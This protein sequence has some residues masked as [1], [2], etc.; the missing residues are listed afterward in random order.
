MRRKKLFA[1]VLTGMLAV[2]TTAC[3][4]ALPGSGT[5]ADREVQSADESASDPA[6]AEDAAVVDGLVGTGPYTV[7]DNYKVD[8]S[9][10]TEGPKDGDVVVDVDFDDGELDGFFTF[11]Q[12]GVEEI[13]NEDGKLV[14]H[15]KNCG[16]VEYSNQLCL[17][18]FS[19]VE[20]CEYSYS[21]DISC[22]I[23]RSVEYRI[24]INGGDYHAYT[25]GILPIGPDELEYTVDFVMKETTDPSPRIIFNLGKLDGMDSDPGEHTVFVDNVK[26]LVK[27]SSNA[28]NSSLTPN[29]T[30][31]AVNQLG[32]RPDDNK[33]AVVKT[34]VRDEDQKFIICDAATNETVYTGTLGERIYDKASGFWVK[35]AVFSDF[36][37]K[38]EYYIASDEGA[39]Y[40]FKIEDDPYFDLYR[41]SV[42]MLSMQRC[43]IELDR[44]F[45]GAY[46]HPAC[47][48]D[49]AVVYDDRSRTVDV[50]G[51]WHDAGDYGRYTVSTAKTIADLL[52]AY[53]SYDAKDDDLGILES[54]NGIPD[55]LDEARVGLD[56]ILKMQDEKSG[57]V[58]HTATCLN[59]PA[60]VLPQR[61]TDQLYVT[62]ISTAATGDFAAVLAK[63]SVIYADIDPE[64]SSE[65][66]EAA[67][68]AW[69]YL[70][71]NEDE[72]F[73][74]PNDVFTG[75]Y[76]DEF[77]LDERYWAATELYLAGE[78]N[79]RAYVLDTAKSP[80]LKRG[81][82]WADVGLYADYDLARSDDDELSDITKEVVIHGA[83]EIS[84]VA[85]WF[86]YFL[87]I[88]QDFPWGS[89]MNVADQA[90]E[91]YMAERLTGNEDYAILAKKQLDYLLGT[92]AMGYSFVTG[93]G[94][95][96]P[97]NPHHRP[98]QYVGK[99]V[100]GMLVGGP[101]RK[102]E[103]PY[104][105]SVLQGEEPALCY[106]D[107]DQSFS[108]NEVTIY[109]NS[110]LI[111][112][113]TA[114]R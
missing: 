37:S 68:R 18:D 104:A 45:G 105:Q 79:L 11:M 66:L 61:E 97:E 8:E 16:N 3:S 106:V 94:T 7:G 110:P 84:L 20:G 90:V 6:K 51:G 5:G 4:S 29:Y 73:H 100:P 67:K 13:G 80:D 39:S 82:G 41:E 46:A 48:T 55:L 96:Y 22:D 109:W 21:F 69:E 107:N 81:L 86:G 44:N 33:V 101:D 28:V 23:E 12:G 87:G 9:K 71:K 58:Y 99:A 56:W 112:M 14:S 49:E 108:T 62:P 76:P 50:S 65:A 42:K 30:N 15:I 111:Y 114:L 19:L 75:E 10:K 93:F 27:D 60:T 43:G 64:F 72:P 92:N 54:G 38:G 26:L 31:V 40:T 52:L 25:E 47:H 95:Y 24:Q 113:L 34:K 70:E 36:T 88:N 102:L 98:S 103:D 85:S 35:K 74:H 32:Y 1:F 91:L 77:L 57:G 17:G 78:D 59:F 89:N 63:A 83:D 53:E 2:S